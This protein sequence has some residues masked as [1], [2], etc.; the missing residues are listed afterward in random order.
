MVGGTELKQ[1]Q[2]AAVVVVSLAVVVLIGIAIITQLKVSSLI[3]NTTSDL[4]IAGLVYFGTFLGVIV[5]GIVGKI[6]I[7][8]FRTK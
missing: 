4:F 2:P 5:I 3:D 6:L 1:L 7:G 8:M